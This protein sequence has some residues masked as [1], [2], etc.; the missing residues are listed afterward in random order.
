MTE[1]ICSDRYLNQF[2]K[3]CS[4]YGPSLPSFTS[5]DVSTGTVIFFDERTKK[6]V[7]CSGTEG[8]YTTPIF[9]CPICGHDFREN[10]SGSFDSL[11]TGTFI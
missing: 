8:E 11:P 6:W 2:D 3:A 4:E 10:E 1:H 7:M 9:F 5:T